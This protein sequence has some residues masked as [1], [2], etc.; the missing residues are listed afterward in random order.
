M[1]LTFPLVLVS[2]L[3]RLGEAFGVQYSK[4]DEYTT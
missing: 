3:D 4:R 1:I 2:W